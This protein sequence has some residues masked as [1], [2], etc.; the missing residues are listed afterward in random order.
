MCTPAPAHLEPLV[1]LGMGEQHLS[2]SSYEDSSASKSTLCE[3]SAI[4]SWDTP[5]S[6]DK[7]L[8]SQ[9]VTVP[10]E[11]GGI[12]TLRN[13]HQADDAA[14]MSWAYSTNEG[15]TAPRAAPEERVKAPL[16]EVPSVQT[17]KQTDF[18]SNLDESEFLQFCDRIDLTDWDAA[19]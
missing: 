1:P 7:N 16:H 11:R 6:P 18:V 4:S 2:H 19:F 5:S 10:R 17:P 14:W 15:S 9:Q 12:G 3:S 8:M 13:R